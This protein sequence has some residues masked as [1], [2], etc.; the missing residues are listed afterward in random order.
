MGNIAGIIVGDAVSVI[1]LAA[2]PL[3]L[4]E[5]VERHFSL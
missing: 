2:A 5:A 3:L 1:V 4:A